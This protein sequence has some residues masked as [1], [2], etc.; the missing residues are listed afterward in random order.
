MPYAWPA[1]LPLPPQ[2]TLH[3]RRA[4]KELGKLQQQVDLRA[5]RLQREVG[6]D[7]VAYLAQ[8]AALEAEW[9]G[10]RRSFGELEGKLTGVTQAA[11]KIGNRLQVRWRGTHGAAWS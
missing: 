11:T 7:Q 6:A 1:W 8:V 2:P 9:A 4:D 10:V 5:E 3:W